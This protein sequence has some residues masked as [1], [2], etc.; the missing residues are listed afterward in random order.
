MGHWGYSRSMFL[1]CAAD[2]V[3]KNCNFYV[4]TNLFQW[5]SALPTNQIANFKFIVVCYKRVLGDTP[6]WRDQIILLVCFLAF[7][8]KVDILEFFADNMRGTSL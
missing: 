3:I 1:E 4:E 7:F 2:R 8:R 6:K 5:S